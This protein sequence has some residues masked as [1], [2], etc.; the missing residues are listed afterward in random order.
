MNRLFIELYLDE[1]VDVL[2]AD[3]VRARGFAAT[4]TQEAGNIGKG[5]E[6]QLD[7]AVSQQKALFT[8][9]REDFEKL[10][11]DYFFSRQKPLW[12]DNC[13]AAFALRSSAATPGDPEQRNGRRNE[14]SVAVYLKAGTSNNVLDRSRAS[15]FYMVSSVLS[16]RPGQHWR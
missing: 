15:G 4:T 9:N 13:G 8:H 10:A 3:L 1:D 11:E 14:E 16:A 12:D 2:I 6:E 7:Y 5:D